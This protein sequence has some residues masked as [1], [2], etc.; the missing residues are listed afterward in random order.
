MQKSRD[1]WPV[2]TSLH[3]SEITGYSTRACEN[4]LSGKVVLPTDALAALMQSEQGRD[5]LAC[6]MTDYTPR[7]W[8]TLRSF[9]N[10]VSKEE[11]LARAQREY[12]E[13]LDEQAARQGP[14]SYE[15]SDPHFHEGRMDPSR[16]MG[17]KKR[18]RR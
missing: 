5:F 10:R 15:I 9:L 18:D 3:L 12:R 16:P 8:T 11:Q 14:H 6:V 13:V 4:W 2:K 17:S 1:F 7:W